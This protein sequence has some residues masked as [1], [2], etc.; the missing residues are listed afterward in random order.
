MDAVL[1]T[2]VPPLW[3]SAEFWGS[4]TQACVAWRRLGLGWRRSALRA[5]SAES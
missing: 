4:P 1:V 5:C 3:G 2:L